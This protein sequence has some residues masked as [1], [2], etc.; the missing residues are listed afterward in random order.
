MNQ[1]LGSK[2]HSA[3]DF[4]RRVLCT[5]SEKEREMDGDRL[6]LDNLKFPTMLGSKADGPSMKILHWRTTMAFNVGT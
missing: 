1:I 6:E 3:G 4:C 5:V 2:F